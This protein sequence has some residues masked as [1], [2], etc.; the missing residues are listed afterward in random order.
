MRRFKLAA[1]L[2]VAFSNWP[3]LA[4]AQG[5]FDCSTIPFEATYNPDVAYAYDQ[6]CG[7]NQMSIFQKL[8]PPAN[9]PPQPPPAPPV[10]FD[11]RANQVF[12]NGFVFDAKDDHAALESKKA[13]YW[14]LVQMPPIPLIVNFVGR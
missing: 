2:F 9:S 7:D 5:Q 13:L 4:H 3:I 8:L 14:P 1:Y 6:E 11:E 10:G 12:V